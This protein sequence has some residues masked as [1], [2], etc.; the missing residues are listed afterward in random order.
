MC[1]FI[2][3]MDA[4]YLNF[5]RSLNKA[6]TL[7][8]KHTQRKAACNCG[9]VGQIQSFHSDEA[10]VVIYQSLSGMSPLSIW[11]E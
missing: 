6:L 2:V 4:I 5:I 7:F 1:V 11:V 3:G 8:T 9:Q 10:A